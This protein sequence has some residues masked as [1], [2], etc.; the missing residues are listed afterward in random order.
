[1]PETATGTFEVQATRHP[2]YLEADGVVLGRM[3]FAKQFSGDLTG[4]STVEMLSA[5]TPVQGSAG[6]VAVERITGAVAGREGSFV[7]LLTGLMDRGRPSLTVSIV[8]DSGTG[9]L[10]GIRGELGIEITGGKHYYTL[11]YTIEG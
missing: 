5:F 10:T 2:P 8:P 7:V 11:T 4:T 9:G 3:S 1:M 6:Y